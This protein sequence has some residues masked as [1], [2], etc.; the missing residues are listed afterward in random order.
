MVGAIVA[1]KADHMRKPA[2]LFLVTGLLFAG[3]AARAAGSERG[4]ILALVLAM[5][6]INNT[7]QRGGEVSVGLTYMTGALVRLGQGCALWLLGKAEPGWAS[8]GALWTG[9]LVGAV[10]GAFLQNH[11]PEG[12]VW[13][14]FCWAFLMTTLAIKLPAEA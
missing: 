12:C 9:L 4:L 11:I 1:V 7:F 14:A 3:A 8:W 6:A 2:V 13:L 10:L 5:G